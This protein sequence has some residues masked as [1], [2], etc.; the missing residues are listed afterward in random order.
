MPN[1]FAHY[2]NGV[3]KPCRHAVDLMLSKHPGNHARDCK[4]EG[5]AK[6]RSA[7]GVQFDDFGH[8][9]V[10]FSDDAVTLSVSFSVN[11]FS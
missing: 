10:S 7:N 11:I 5:A 8:F 3:F 1:H 9:L 4:S 2:H 6:R